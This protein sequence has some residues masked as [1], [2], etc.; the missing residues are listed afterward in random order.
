MKIIF[1]PN[2]FNWQ[3][4]IRKLV[5]VLHFNLEGKFPIEKS[6]QQWKFDS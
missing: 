1:R 5:E 6:F 2:Q 3:I 4:L